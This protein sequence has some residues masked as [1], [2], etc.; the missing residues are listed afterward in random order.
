MLES[1]R[2]WLEQ[3]RAADAV[4]RES[5]GPKVVAVVANS[6]DD[7]AYWNARLE[8][9]ARE[10]YN[11]EAPTRVL[12]I[13]EAQPLGNLHGTIAAWQQLDRAHPGALASGGIGL[14]S[15]AIGKG[16]RLSPFT[17]AL[18]NRKAAFP[19]PRR[20]QD[21]RA[22]R[23]AISELANWALHATSARLADAGFRGLVIKWGDEAIVPDRVTIPPGLDPAACDV[24]RFASAAEPTDDLAIHK[25]WLV[26]D[27]ASGALVDEI[28]RQPLAEL[29]ERLA[30]LA[31]RGQTVSVNL[32]SFCASTQFFAALALAFAE[33]LAAGRRGTDWDPW[34]WVAWCCADAAAWERERAR[35]AASSRTGLA[36]VEDRTPDFFARVSDAKARF[37]AIHG[38]PVRVGVVDLGS[39][40]W[41]DFGNH[42]ALCEHWNALR[43]PDG[44]GTVLRALYGL[45]GMRDARGNLVAGGR[46]EERADVRDSVIVDAVIPG[47]SVMRGGIVI[48]GSYGRIA[49]PDGGAAIESRLEHLECGG[50]GAV[51]FRSIGGRLELGN[52]DKHT[53]LALPD[54]RIDLRG[55]ES[56]R[57]YSGAS[58]TDPVLGN[59]ISFE[60]AGR[61]MEAFRIDEIERMHAAQA[62]RTRA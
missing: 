4:V 50:P 28:P 11:A 59:P 5:R 13:A 37:A 49:M 20:F 39:T 41:V 29:R 24:I 48:G 56:I 27:P 47:G 33:P 16:T 3:L 44:H 1:E 19:T 54:R 12:G 58:Y 7:A 8:V 32:G 9:T 55:S 60:A 53:T 42:A 21:P 35:E 15:I 36:Q 34:F 40:L 18:G 2:L 26:V 30:P 46:I 45:P 17:Q 57:D 23:V 31:T 62:D 25:E 61:I 22:G 52:G 43:A 51:S 10:L 14:M 6:K 38:R